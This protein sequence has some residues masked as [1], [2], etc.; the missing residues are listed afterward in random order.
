MVNTN[1]IPYREVRKESVKIQRDKV[2]V[3]T[4]ISG[5]K[6]KV[7]NENGNENKEMGKQRPEKYSIHL[8]TPEDLRRLLCSVVN[9]LRKSTDGNLCSRSSRIITA[10]QVLLNIF[11]QNE[12]EQ[13]VRNLE[14]RIG[15][16]GR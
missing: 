13:R 14:E 5:K 3:N 4:Q 7:S 11:Q 2:I 1:T 12:L 9:D 16:G 6:D 8:K 10:A 15:Y